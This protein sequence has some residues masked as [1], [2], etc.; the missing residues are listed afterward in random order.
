MHACGACLRV[1][2]AC[3]LTLRTRGQLLGAESIMTI[4][5]LRSSFE[6]L[7][8]NK[9]FKP[10][11]EKTIKNAVSDP[12]SFTPS[13]E[14]EKNL[15][16]QLKSN[17]RDLLGHI[18]LADIARVFSNIWE[19]GS[20]DFGAQFPTLL[21]PRN[22]A[23]DIP[24]V[25]QIVQTCMLSSF[26]SFLFSF[27]FRSNGKVIED[28][29]YMFEGVGAFELKANT[30]SNPDEPTPKK[31]DPLD[32]RAVVTVDGQ[33]SPGSLSII[34]NASDKLASL[35]MC[36]WLS[37][38]IHFVPKALGVVD[39]DWFPIVTS[40]GNSETTS[41]ELSREAWHFGD[42]GSL[43]RITTLNNF[44]LL[45]DAWPDHEVFE[46]RDK[47]LHQSSKEIATRFM[48]LDPIDRQ[49]MTTA[50]QFYASVLAAT[51]SRHAILNLCIA[52][53]C[54]L[55]WNLID[56]AASGNDPD[57]RNK[58]SRMGSRLELIVGGNAS[59]RREA[60]D[61]IDGLYAI[62]N[63]IAHGR[64]ANIHHSNPNEIIRRGMWYFRLSCDNLVKTLSD[65]GESKPGV[66]RLF[67]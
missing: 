33:F 66:A 36:G 20:V 38:F 42:I 54:L 5:T 55:G 3:V 26:G 48:G 30:S 65:A 4:Q 6:K 63:Y 11:F 27:P 59:K 52:L 39:E 14:D 40:A 35:L 17:H 46:A 24:K 62:R 19:K 47:E 8:I 50:F 64:N 13:D 16:T 51:S 57:W 1:Y 9:D 18:S 31:S 41:Y 56:K 34:P 44:S 60:L 67:M 32:C 37:R 15:E 12:F 21:G 45:R 49:R 58:R 61:F 22:A 2:R 29:A 7:L 43:C 53:E 10:L 28:R 25:T 23:L